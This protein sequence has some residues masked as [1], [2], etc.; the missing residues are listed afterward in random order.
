MFLSVAMCFRNE[1]H[2]LEE[3]MDHY[4]DE[5][6]DQFLLCD[7]K[8]TDDY[9]SILDK[10]D[11]VVLYKDNSQQIQWSCQRPHGEYGPGIYS[12]MISENETDWVI[13]VD[14]DEF[15]YARE[16]YDTI[17]QFLQERGSEFNQ[18]LVPISLFHNR[19]GTELAIKKQPKSVI[20]T[21]VLSHKRD[22]QVKCIVKTEAIKHLNLHEHVVD[23]ISTRPHLKDKFKLHTKASSTAKYGSVKSLGGWR[24]YPENEKVYVHCNHY[25]YQ[26]EEYFFKIK[27]ARGYGDRKDDV[28]KKEQHRLQDWWA[29]NGKEYEKDYVLYNKKRK[30]EN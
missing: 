3:W 1:S 14:A 10:Y 20:D 4:V 2:I 9:Q 8:S 27:S 24:F 26:S 13:I 25:K 5:G 12:K 6:V 16:G 21:F 23:G 11:N 29:A 18:L 19:S 7:N 15:M 30:K 17:K 28:A 22:K